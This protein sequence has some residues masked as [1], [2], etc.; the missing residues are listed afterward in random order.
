MELLLVLWLLYGAQCVTWLSG[1]GTWFVR[2]L[3]AWLATRG[4]GWRLLPLL[5]SAPALRAA[6]FPLLERDGELVARGAATWRSWQRSSDAGFVVERESLAG[7]IARKRVVWLD[8]HPLTH[9]ATPEEAEATAQRLRNLA[10]PCA[11]W[12]ELLG[13][14]LREQ[15]SFTA[16]AANSLRVGNATRWLG[17]LADVYFVLG[18]LLLPA[19][20]IWLGTERALYLALAPLAL[21]HVASLVAFAR[22]HREL[23]P[24]ARGALAEALWSAALYPPALLRARH[25]L[26]T[27]SLGSF[28][29]AVVAAAALPEGAREGFLRGELVRAQHAAAEAKRAKQTLGLAELE[30]RA[31]RELLEAAGESEALLL[32]PPERSD[33]A[34]R[35]YCPA[36]LCEYRRASGACNDC[37]VPLA[38]L[39]A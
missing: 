14:V 17:R 9:C 22:A 25:E 27:R 37:R 26:A 23:R 15:L 19:A 29:P 34:A 7:A 11:P 18:M 38:P 8:D 35:A 16:Y 31:L 13:E 5:P 12:P 30:L 6:R 33:P 1:D 21:L 32:E 24:G 28:H 2:P 36:C 4:P 3:R 20:C 39:R 10:A